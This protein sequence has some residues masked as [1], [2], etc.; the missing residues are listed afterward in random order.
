MIPGSPPLE[1]QRQIFLVASGLSTMGSFAG[2]TAKGWVLMDGTHQPMLLA[3]H[4]ALLSLPT[5]VVSGPAG[6]VTDRHGCERVLVWAQWG[7]LL[8][9]ALGA[10]AIPLTQGRSQ[11][12]L[13]LFS[14][15][16][17]GLAS[18]Y[19]LTA[20]NKYCALLVNRPEELGPYLTSFSVVFNV[21][22]LVGPPIGGALVAFTGPAMALLL[23]AATYL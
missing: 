8:G 9:A 7:L 16:V 2:L 1:R 18:A 12:A 21:G 14:T 3:L 22:K 5:L 4:F 10:L 19:E 11:A 15:L 17:V 6:V 23:D 13:L 20:R